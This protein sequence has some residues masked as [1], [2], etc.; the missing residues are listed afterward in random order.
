MR[1]ILT[2]DQLE[3]IAIRAVHD[4]FGG[5]PMNNETIAIAILR[6]I[7]AVDKAEAQ[8]VRF[9]SGFDD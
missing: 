8:E 4:A 6:V 2:R 3:T 9:A 5:E 7:E 1:A